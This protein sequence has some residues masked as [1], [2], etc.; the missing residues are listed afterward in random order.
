MRP[1]SSPLEGSRLPSLLAIHNAFVQQTELGWDPV[2][3]GHLSSLWKEAFLANHTAKQHL[4]QQQ[5][6]SIADRWMNQLINQLWL[7]SK[8]IWKYRNS[9]VHGQAQ[10]FYLS[11]TLSGLRKK[12][13]A[14]YSRFQSDPFMVPQAR[15]FLFNKPLEAT[16]AMDTE[17]V[18]A[19]IRS[20]EEALLTREHREQLMQ[21]NHLL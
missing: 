1:C 20:V 16:L 19:W 12:V 14:L 6:N 8:R 17:S 5:L 4:S 7:F 3:Q 11:K 2:I 9:V 18:R 13:T 21:A 10:Q 15:N